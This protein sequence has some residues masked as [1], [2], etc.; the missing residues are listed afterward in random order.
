MASLIPQLPFN[1][2]L[3]TPSAADVKTMHQIRVLD[4][5]DGLS[6]N[7]HPKGLFSI[8]IFG[9]V[10]EERR[11][12]LFGYIDL[13]IEILHPVL[14]KSITDLKQLYGGILSGREYATWDA[15]TKDFIASDALK[16]QTG[17]TFFC[18]HYPDL[19]FESRPSAKREFN[20]RLI[21]QYRTDSYLRYM[22]VMPAG[23]RDYEVDD[24]G[25]PSEDEINVLYR[26][27]IS[28]VSVIDNVDARNN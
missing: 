14:Y 28:I 26:K 9:K 3:F 12:R 6:K 19:V 22:L 21:D 2:S 8:D 18:K 13:H 15:T 17:Y 27:V 7:F 5:F 25:K 20:I 4:I 23:L 11:N 24:N 16:G 10:G 1:I